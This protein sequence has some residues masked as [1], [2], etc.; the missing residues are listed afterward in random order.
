MLFGTCLFLKLL[1]FLF[2]CS[3]YRAAKKKAIE[4]SEAESNA[5]QATPTEEPNDLISNGVIPSE[6][7]PE[8]DYHLTPSYTEST[9]CESKCSLNETTA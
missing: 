3:L 6:T 9:I 1:T 7:L 8:S 5:Y 2:L 4:E